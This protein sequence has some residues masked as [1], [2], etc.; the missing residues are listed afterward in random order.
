[1]FML[2]QSDAAAILVC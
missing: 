1:M 2:P